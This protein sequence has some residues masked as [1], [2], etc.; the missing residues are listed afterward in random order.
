MVLRK[1]T[2]IK[3]TLFLLRSKQVFGNQCDH[4][5][6]T[7]I[8]IKGR[9]LP[10]CIEFLTKASYNFGTG[11]V[12]TKLLSDRKKGSEVRLADDNIELLLLK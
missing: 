3:I 1:E 8:V 12:R 5:E 7:L 11:R 2:A 10:F 4:K 6:K 9:V